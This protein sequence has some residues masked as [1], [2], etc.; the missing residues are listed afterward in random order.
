MFSLLLSLL[1]VFV[2]GPISVASD[3]LP[4]MFPTCDRPKS[5]N[6]RCPVLLIRTKTKVRE[7]R[8]QEFFFFF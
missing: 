1:F 2:S 6:L 5:I 7:N 8:F 4:F 3:V